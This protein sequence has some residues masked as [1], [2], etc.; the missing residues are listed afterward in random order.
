[1]I[2]WGRETGAIVGRP[3]V[4]SARAACCGS[5]LYLGLWAGVRR[6]GPSSWGH[7]KT[8]AL[9]RC[10]SRR[11]SIPVRGV[12]PTKKPRVG[13]RRP[14]SSACPKQH[15][16]LA[17][18][19]PRLPRRRARRSSP[20]QTSLA[21]P[22]DGVGVC[23]CTPNPGRSPDPTTAVFE[24]DVT[25]VQDCARVDAIAQYGEGAPSEDAVSYRVV[26]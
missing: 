19:T 24:A 3:G 4:L 1:M 25:I 15:A 21:Q 11:H 9:S 7:R 10:V 16:R 14:R 8:A 23:H 5:S 13:A 26:W 2:M 18:R 17:M 22:V 6:P 12:K 20:Q